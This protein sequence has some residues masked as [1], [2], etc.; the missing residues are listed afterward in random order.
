MKIKILEE[1]FSVADLERDA[2]VNSICRIP[3]LV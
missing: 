1:Q 2:A 3:Y